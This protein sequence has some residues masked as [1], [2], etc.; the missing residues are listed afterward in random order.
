MTAETEPPLSNLNCN[1][2]SKNTRIF[3]D[4]TKEVPPTG[5]PGV[6]AARH[7]R[8][9]KE[10]QIELWTYLARMFQDHLFDDLAAKVISIVT[11]RASESSCERT[12]SRQKRII[13]HS[14][15]RSSPELVRAGLALEFSPSPPR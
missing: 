2:N 14:R 13:A 10:K 4:A 15:I 7:W 9:F 12:F 11:I 3:R 6:G 5:T 8:A 1:S